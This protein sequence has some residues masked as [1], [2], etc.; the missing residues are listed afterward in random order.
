MK[1]FATIVAGALAC[2]FNAP[3]KCYGEVEYNTTQTFSTLPEPDQAYPEMRSS[4]VKTPSLLRNDSKKAF[5][6]TMGPC[7]NKSL[8]QSYLSTGEL[9][10]CQLDETLLNWAKNQTE[11]MCTWGFGELAPPGNSTNSLD[12]T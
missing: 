1:V 6:G 12:Y 8:Y 2:P 9:Y 3:S 11:D 10:H 4:V 5:L 7:G